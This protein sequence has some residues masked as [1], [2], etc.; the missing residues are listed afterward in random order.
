MSAH[1]FG[2]VTLPS[3]LRPFVDVYQLHHDR[4]VGTA[5][6]LDGWRDFLAQTLANGPLSLMVSAREHL[7]HF[8]DQEARAVDELLGSAWPETIALGIA[9]RSLKAHDGVPADTATLSLP[10]WLVELE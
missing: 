7:S 10:H 6:L 1:L 3:D 8:A 9:C 4:G 5:T 2:S